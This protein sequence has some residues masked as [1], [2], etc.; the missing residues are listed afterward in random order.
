MLFDHVIVAPSARRESSIGACVLVFCR[1][2]VCC[3]VTK[4]ASNDEMSGSIYGD[5]DKKASKIHFQRFLI[6]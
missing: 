3:W 2:V 5:D 6:Y 1:Y 4:E